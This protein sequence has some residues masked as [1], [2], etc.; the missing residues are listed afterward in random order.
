MTLFNEGNPIDESIFLGALKH[1]E[2][3]ISTK[4]NTHTLHTYTYGP[5]REKT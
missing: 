2:I 5:W 4:K 3:H 1:K